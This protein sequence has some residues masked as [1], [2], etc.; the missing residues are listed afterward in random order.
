MARHYDKLIRY[1]DSWFADLMDERKGFTPEECWQVMIAIRECQREGNTKPI[2][3][4]PATIARGLSMATLIEQVEIILDKINGASYRGKKGAQAQKIALSAEAAA[5]AEEQRTKN[6][7]KEKY[8]ESMAAFY[9]MTREKFN[10]S[11]YDIYKLDGDQS[12]LLKR[13]YEADKEANALQFDKWL[14]Y[15]GLTELNKRAAQ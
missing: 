6:E 13:I 15:R 14:K 10:L 12:E 8:E 1:Y 5:A 3:N 7:A 11:S 9:K 2:E 4:L